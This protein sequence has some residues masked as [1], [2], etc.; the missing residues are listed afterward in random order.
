MNS[1]L[2]SVN[3]TSLSDEE[4]LTALLE[5]NTQLVRSYFDRKS[6][7]ATEQIRRL[8]LDKDATFRGFGKRDSRGEAQLV[9]SLAPIRDGA[10]GGRQ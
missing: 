9:E 3:F 6:A 7:A 1:D 8:F 5:A 4:F 2:A 10:N